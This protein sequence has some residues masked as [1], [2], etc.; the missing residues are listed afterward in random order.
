MVGS[1]FLGLEFGV[2]K[3]Q[4]TFFSFPAR[5]TVGGVWYFVLKSSGQGG[6]MLGLGDKLELS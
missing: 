2:K 4:G 6:P 1:S 3:E 5:C